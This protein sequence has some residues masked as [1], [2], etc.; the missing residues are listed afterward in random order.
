MPLLAPRKLT[1]GHGLLAAMLLYFVA[2][3]F[4]EK[5]SVGKWL[6]GRKQELYPMSTFS[7]FLQPRL[8][9]AQTYAFVVQQPGKPPRQVSFFDMF[10]PLTRQDLEDEITYQQLTHLEQS[11]QSGCPTYQPYGHSQCTGQQPFTL[12][13][14][15]QAMW[16][17]S[18][19]K[20]GIHPPYQLTYV[21][22]RWDFSA[23]DMTDVI[24]PKTVPVIHFKVNKG[25]EWM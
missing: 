15:M 2:N 16:V 17:N 8:T 21:R 3:A 19:Q 18:L 20:M 13:A 4:V 5:S 10:A 24:G 22:L 12:P 1:F 7:V 11:I 9:G 23:T 6:L 25:F 14:D